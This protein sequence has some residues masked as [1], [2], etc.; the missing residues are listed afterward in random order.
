MTAWRSCRR[1]S[2]KRRSSTCKFMW[3]RRETN[4]PI[5]SRLLSWAWSPLLALLFSLSSS[6]TKKHTH[7]KQWDWSAVR[8]SLRHWSLSGSNWIAIIRARSTRLN[9]NR[10]CCRLALIW[11]IRRKLNKSRVKLTEK[12]HIYWLKSRRKSEA[13]RRCT[14]WRWS[15]YRKNYNKKRNST[16][17]KNTSSRQDCS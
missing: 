14:P 13:K 17:K 1:V 7:C 15:D 5:W 6:S 3:R 16:M 8:I 10:F 11:H 12:R 2:T 4:G 9:K